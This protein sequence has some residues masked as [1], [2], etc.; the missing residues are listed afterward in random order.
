MLV[1]SPKLIADCYVL[2]RS[3]KSRHPPYALV[4][5]ALNFLPAD[6]AGRLAVS[7]CQLLAFFTYNPNSTLHDAVRRLTVNIIIIISADKIIKNITVK[8]LVV[9]VPLTRKMIFTNRFVETI[10][11]LIID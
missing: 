2:H 7:N 1:T 3:T 5:T 6:E 10:S 11:A 8:T 9:K 4:I